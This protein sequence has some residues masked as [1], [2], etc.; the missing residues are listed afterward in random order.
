MCVIREETAEVDHGRMADNDMKEKLSV[1][2]LTLHPSRGSITVPHVHRGRVM[3]DTQY[4]E[5]LWCDE[6][7]FRKAHLCHYERDPNM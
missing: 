2:S 6:L 3:N 1:C 5:H 7:H 4:E